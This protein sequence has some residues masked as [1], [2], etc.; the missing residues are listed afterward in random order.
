MRCL[1]AA[2]IAAISAIVPGQI[3]SAADMPLKAPPPVAA[4]YNWTGFYV[5]GNLGYS[6]GHDPSTINIGNPFIKQAPSF[7]LV[8]AGWLAGGQLGYNWQTGNV[9]VGLEADWQWT[10]QTDSACLS[11]CAPSTENPAIF[12]G[13]AVEQKLKWFGTARAR[14]GSAAN[15]WL[16]YLTGG[17]AWGRVETSVPFLTTP[18]TRGASF[19]VTKGGWT[20]GAGV[21]T[22]LSGRW[23]GKLEYLYM[24]LGSV[25]GIIFVPGIFPVSVPVTSDIRDHIIRV[26]LNYRFAGGPAAAAAGPIYRTP[27]VASY[28]W[29]GFYAG[30]NTGYSIGRDRSTEQFFAPDPLTN[31]SYRLGP[32]GWLAGGQLGYNWQTGNVV[33]G[34]E[35]DWQWTGQKDSACVIFCASPQG[36]GNYPFFTEEQK[37]KW[38]GTARARIGYAAD[39]WLWYVTGGVAWGQIETNVTAGNTVTPATVSAGFSH[40][41]TG[42]VIGAGVETALA[43]NWSAKFEYLYMQL[44][45]TTDTLF[46]TIPGCTNC[47]ITTSSDIRDHVVRAGLNYRFAATAV[48][49]R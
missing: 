11:L 17:A 33:A 37:L 30:L 15:D 39:H 5:G 22:A 47:T 12:F 45:S 19:D 20:L 21:E 10:G 44:G 29:A 36:G 13:T 31:E 26:G 28:N 49:A 35:A 6:V 27:P 38:F 7:T 24:N 48:A 40:T 8:P 23:S 9:V 18:E 25:G 32:A 43:G 46:Y 42:G 1:P 4:F 34:L 2:F 3:A 41:K 16:W 14:V